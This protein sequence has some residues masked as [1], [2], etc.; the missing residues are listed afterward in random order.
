MGR[1]S[2]R[3]LVAVLSMLIVVAAGVL[4]AGRT[5]PGGADSAEAR[6]AVFLATG[7]DA[8]DLCGVVPGEV[9]HGCHFCRLLPEPPQAGP[10]RLAARTI[11][12]V[13][14]LAPAGTA[15]GP[16]RGH[17]RVLPR[18]PPALV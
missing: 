2:A 18:A 7:G 17:A 14:W 15:V 6:L 16:Q 12:A 10:A 3:T 9:D 5:A 11:E 13:P 1:I 4:S 8:A